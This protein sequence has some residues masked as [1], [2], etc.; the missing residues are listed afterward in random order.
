MN[1]GKKVA[2]TAGRIAML[3][4]KKAAQRLLRGSDNG[5]DDELDTFDDDEEDDSY[6]DAA[7]DD[8]DYQTFRS[9]EQANVRQPK[10]SPK[11]KK[12]SKKRKSMDAGDAAFRSSTRSRPKKRSNT[13][14]YEVV[15]DPITGTYTVG[16]RPDPESRRR[17]STSNLPSR[18]LGPVDPALGPSPYRQ[19]QR[20]QYPATGQLSG[21]DEQGEDPEISPEPTLPS[22]IR[23]QNRRR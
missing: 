14:I 12:T 13:S 17:S 7:D 2:I 19:V 15:Q 4:K 22:S 6:L 23:R 9:S 1:D 8:K 10:S 16:S 18:S 3:K 5:E 11:S 20:G 21:P